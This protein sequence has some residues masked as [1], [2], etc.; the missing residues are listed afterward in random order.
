M[1]CNADMTLRF[2]FVDRLLMQRCI[3]PEFA[4]AW[5]RG[6]GP[7]RTFTHRRARE[8]ARPDRTR[9]SRQSGDQIAPL[10]FDDADRL[11]GHVELAATAS[12]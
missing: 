4:K 1:I 6:A 10:S 3:C 8:P 5:K 12:Q 11:I 2:E 7:I 9:Q